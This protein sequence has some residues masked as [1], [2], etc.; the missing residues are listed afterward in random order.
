MA[1][2]LSRPQ[3]VD[4]ESAPGPHLDIKTIFPVIG[5]PIIKINY[6][7]NGNP[8]TGKVPF[9]TKTVPSVS[10]TTTKKKTHLVYTHEYRQTS[11]ISSTYE[12]KLLFTQMCLEAS[13]ISAAPTTSSFLIYT[14][15][16]WI[17]QR[18]LQD[19]TINI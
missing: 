17:G 14:W 6:F 12:I 19:K 10:K 11:N 3:C 8:Y 7:Y 5:I 16:Q 2:I 9:Y 1:V 13:P 15:L 18:Q 4:I